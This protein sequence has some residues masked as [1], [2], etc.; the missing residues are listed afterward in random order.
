MKFSVYYSIHIDLNLIDNDWSNMYIWSKDYLVQGIPC[1]AHLIL[2]CI[3]LPN[4]WSKDYLVQGIPCLVHLIFTWTGPSPVVQVDLVQ[5][6]HLPIVGWFL[7]H[8]Y[9]VTDIITC[10]QYLNVKLQQV[11]THFFSYI[12]GIIKNYVE[13]SNNL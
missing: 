8:V 10:K 4:D 7:M 2:T 12:R 1:L 3:V 6:I 13:F 9:G 11:K 5:G